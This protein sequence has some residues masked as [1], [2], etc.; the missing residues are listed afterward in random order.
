[1][2]KE[3]NKRRERGM[4]KWRKSVRNEEEGGEARGGGERTEG[5]EKGRGTGSSEREKSW[6]S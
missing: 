3:R 6:G 4:A 5:T 1:M 2:V